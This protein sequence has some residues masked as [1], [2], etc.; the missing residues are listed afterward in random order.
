MKYSHTKSK[1]PKELE[2]ISKSRDLRKVSSHKT[3]ERVY[4]HFHGL[5]G[6]SLGASYDKST[7]EI[8]K[9]HRADSIE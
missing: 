5:F 7:G 8:S 6:G 4:G 2:K 9:T 3:V 1:T